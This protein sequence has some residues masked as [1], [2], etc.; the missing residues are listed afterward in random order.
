MPTGTHQNCGSKRRACRVS[1][2]WSPRTERRSGHRHPFLTQ[3]LP[4]IEGHLQMKT[5]SSPR[6]SHRGINYSLGRVT[7]LA[8]DGQRKTQP[9]SG[10]VR[11][12][13]KKS[14]KIFI[15]F[16]YFIYLF[17]HSFIQLVILPPLNSAGPLIYI[18]AS[19][20]VFSWDSGVRTSE[21]C[22]SVSRVFSWARFLLF[23]LVQCVSFCFTL[24]Q[25]IVFYFYPL[26]F[27]LS[28]N[29]RQIRW[30]G[31]WR[32]IGGSGGWRNHNQDIFRGIKKAIFNKRKRN[33]P[34][35]KVA[36]QK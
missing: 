14:F 9:V 35:K 6:E 27:C 34:N 13:F 17:I 29:Q 10:N 26:E 3:M 15:S 33:K 23:V 36:T 20:L 16:I 31:R 30:K 25:C 7:S 2:R 1:T 24:L 11:T 12:F 5:Q 4:S 18:M 21:S 22:I 19:R 8:V 28:S 32:G